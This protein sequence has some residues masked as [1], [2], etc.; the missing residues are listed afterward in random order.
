MSVPAM[1]MQVHP[2]I[3][4]ATMDRDMYLKGVIRRVDAHAIDQPGIR[5]RIFMQNL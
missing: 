3:G 5:V 4:V 1:Q 2:Y